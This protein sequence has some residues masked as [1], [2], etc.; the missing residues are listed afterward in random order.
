LYSLGLQNQVKLLT[1]VG[2]NLSMYLSQQF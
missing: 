2:H 1:S